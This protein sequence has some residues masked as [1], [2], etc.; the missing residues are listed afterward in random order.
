MQ[1]DKHIDVRTRNHIEQVKTILK[2]RLDLLEKDIGFKKRE[3][4]LRAIETLSLSQLNK[5]RKITVNLA[6][7]ILAEANKV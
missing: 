7:K 3:E 5:L 1:E 4:A 2:L 6:N